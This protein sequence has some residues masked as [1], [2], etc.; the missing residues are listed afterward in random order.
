MK[1]LTVSLALVAGLLLQTPAAADTLLIERV[2]VAEG[3]TL[4][5]RGQSMAQVEQAYGAPTQKH[6]PLAGPR[7]EEHTS[8]LQSRENL[9]CR[10]LLEKKNKRIPPPRP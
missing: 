7:S 10:P 9:V 6:A 2:Q 5:A 3:K 1:A 4:P 8:E